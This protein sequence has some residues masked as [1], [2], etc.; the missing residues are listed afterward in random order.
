MHAANPPDV[1]A[2]SGPME[3][4]SSGSTG[5]LRASDSET[6]WPAF[7]QCAGWLSC[8]REWAGQRVRRI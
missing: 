1:L 2:I 5:C 6:T 4:A 8:V 3:A 7:V